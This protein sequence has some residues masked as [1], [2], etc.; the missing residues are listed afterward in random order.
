MPIVPE[1]PGRP[2]T[3]KAG[4]R[5]SISLMFT[6]AM[7]HNSPKN[8]LKFNNDN[9]IKIST[10]P[11]SDESDESEK[12]V[13]KRA[14]KHK[15]SRKSMVLKD[16]MHNQIIQFNDNFLKNI[17]ELDDE[18]DNLA[19]NKDEEG[20]EVEIVG[21]CGKSN[22]GNE[23]GAVKETKEERSE[24][25]LKEIKEVKEEYEQKSIS[26]L[27]STNRPNNNTIN[28]NTNPI[29]RSSTTD[30]F[31]LISFQSNEFIK[32]ITSLED[33]IKN[34]NK[35]FESKIF[36]FK[37]LKQFITF[38]LKEE[39]KLKFEL[40]HS[41]TEINKNYVKVVETLFENKLIGSSKNTNNL[42]V[43]SVTNKAN[44]KSYNNNSLSINNEISIN[45]EGHKD[46]IDKTYLNSNENKS[47][48]RKIIQVDSPINSHN[49]NNFNDNNYNENSFIKNEFD[50][51][52]NKTYKTFNIQFG[53]NSGNDQFSSPMNKTTLQSDFY[54]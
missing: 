17:S 35:S 5:N 26:D 39:D 54:S 49:E 11:S 52:M 6:S 32:A 19:F 47:T 18:T 3:K 10:I 41:F 46:L 53:N 12:K 16:I 1:T 28:N 21:E 20:N 4:A 15:K 34:L 14:P 45:E 8:L 42:S 24:S 43:T 30:D 48:I 2:L 40:G 44:N 36:N 9:I 31:Q 7:K 22:E 25:K 38:I 23:G 37:D 50:N 13:V 27:K 29:R 51:D 33:Q